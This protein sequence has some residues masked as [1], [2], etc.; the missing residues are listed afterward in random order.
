M[1]G[2]KSWFQWSL[3]PSTAEARG[4][5]DRIGTRGSVSMEP[6]S[7]DRGGTKNGWAAKDGWKSFNG[8]AVLRPRRP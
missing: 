7:F 1:K 8:A 2:W 5:P 3:G 6:R 4:V